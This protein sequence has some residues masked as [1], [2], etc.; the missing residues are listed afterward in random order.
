MLNL[1]HEFLVLEKVK[2]FLELIKVSDN[3]I[4]HLL[5]TITSKLKWDICLHVKMVTLTLNV[6]S[7]NLIFRGR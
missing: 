1:G 2:F 4:K 3:Y 5:N 6:N 7:R